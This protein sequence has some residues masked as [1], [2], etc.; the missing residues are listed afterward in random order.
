MSNLYNLSFYSN[1]SIGS[2]Q[3]QIQ[4]IIR[5]D[6]SGFNIPKNSYIHNNHSHPR[7]LFHCINDIKYQE[8]L[9]IYMTYKNQFLGSPD[10]Y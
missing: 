7:I 2:P 8:F 1:I 5:L 4:L 3:Q 10:M 6:K 9:V